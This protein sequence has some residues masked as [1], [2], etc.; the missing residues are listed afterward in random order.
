VYGLRADPTSS[1]DTLV[2]LLLPLNQAN[3]VLAQSA[4]GRIGLVKVTAGSAGA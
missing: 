3:Q 4:V 1:T 2:T